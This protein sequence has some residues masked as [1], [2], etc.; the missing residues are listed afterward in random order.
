MD[1]RRAACEAFRVRFQEARVPVVL[2]RMFIMGSAWAAAM[3]AVPQTVLAQATPIQITV[4]ET[5]TLQL[6]GNPSTGYTWALDDVP[7]AYSNTVSV[8]VRGY[9][10]RDLKP[11]ERPLLGAAQ[12]FRVLLTGIAPGRA[13]LVFKYVKGDTAAPATTKEF[14]V[15]VLDAAPKAAPQEVQEEPI[16]DPTS[17]RPADSRDDLFADPQD[18]D[19]AGGNDDP[20]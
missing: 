7:A 14:A 17:D 15:E 11:G 8:D 20:D 10:A 5:A 12:K 1:Q 19:D 18:N 4:G 2:F 3:L 9:G 16:D 13:S 6:D